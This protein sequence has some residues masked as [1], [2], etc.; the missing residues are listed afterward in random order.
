MSEPTFKSIRSDFKGN[1][2]H[3]TLSWECLVSQ[4]G[5]WL[6]GAQGTLLK[7][8]AQGRVPVAQVHRQAGQ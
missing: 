6:E 3:A 2:P 1:D 4:G 5:L 7:A 8:G